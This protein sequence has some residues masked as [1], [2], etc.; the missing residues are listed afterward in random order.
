MTDDQRAKLLLLSGPVGVGKTTVGHELS[1]RLARRAVPH[2]FVDL[3]ALAQTFPRAQGDPFGTGL[4]LRNLRAVWSN[5]RAAG[6]KLLIVSRVVENVDDVAAIERAVALSPAITCQLSASEQTLA[7]QIARR[8]V[9]TGFERQRKRAIELA[10]TLASSGPADF[11]V[12]TDGGTVADIADEVLR[13]S[14]LV[15]V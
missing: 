1:E 2:T 7:E 14:G 5:A 12:E 13:H 10:R 15:S 11:T 4:A 9:G 8:E 3:D 6:A